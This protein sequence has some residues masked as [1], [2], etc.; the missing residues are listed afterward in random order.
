MAEGTIA[1]SAANAG[2][3]PVLT[4]TPNRIYCPECSARL[5]YGGTNWL[6]AVMVVSTSPSRCSP[7]PSDT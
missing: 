1:P 4:P 2:M 5:R 7:W 3:G 6:I